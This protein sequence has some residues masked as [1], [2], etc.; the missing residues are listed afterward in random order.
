VEFLTNPETENIFVVGDDDQSIYGW[1]GSDI[2]NILKFEKEFPRTQKIFME[3]NYR[4]TKNIIE[5]SNFVIEKNE[6]RYPKKLF[7]EKESGEKIFIYNAFSEKEES[8]FIAKKIKERLGEKISENEI[9]ILY[10]ANFQSR[11]LEEA[12]LRENI[13]YQVLGTK[14]FD[15]AEVKDIISYI[16]AAKN[17]ESLVDIKRII[18]SPKRGIGKTSIV[19]IF[20]ANEGEEILLPPKTQKSFENFKKILE[21]IRNFIEK[22]EDTTMSE[23]VKFVIE[24]SGY[25]KFLN[26]KKNRRRY[27]KTFKYL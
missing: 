5:A 26:E 9:A 25:K 3:Q 10:R 24:K 1:R 6:K 18:N 11:V 8:R 12:M 7:T 2:E 19:K 4:S 20:S 22:D 17:P 13:S 27:G 16:R 14:F 15:R 23:I 21:E